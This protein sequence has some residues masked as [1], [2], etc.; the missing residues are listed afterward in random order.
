MA[1]ATSPTPVGTVQVVDPHPLN[2]L[3][4]T[5]NT[6]EEPVRTD[7]RGHIVGA[8]ME[9]SS[10]VDETTLEVRLRKGLRYQ[11]GEEFTAENF[12]RAFE[13]VQRWKAPHPPGT[14]INFHRETRL[15]MVDSHR[16]D[17]LPPAGRAGARQV[18]RFPSAEHPVLG[19][20]GVRLPQARLSRRPLVSDRRTGPVGHRTVHPG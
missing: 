17:G 10:W 14:S 15:E 1:G 20:G 18:P 16:P 4:I 5:W 13:E 6:M 2:W 11:D 8:A 7:E 12:R 3:F 19:G 9:E